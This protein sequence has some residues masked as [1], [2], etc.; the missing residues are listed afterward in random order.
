M[1]GV[2]TP[3]LTAAYDAFFAATTVEQQM[4]AAKEFNMAVVRQHNQVC[5]PLAARYQVSQPWV[6]GF[7]GEWALGDRA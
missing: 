5:G 3:E 2:E 1:G 6:G 7:N 4:E